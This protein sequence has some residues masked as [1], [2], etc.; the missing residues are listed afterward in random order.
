MKKWAKIDRAT[1]NVLK[2][3]REKELKRVLNK[4]YVWIE[5]VQGTSDV[6]DS[7]TH[8]LKESVVLPD[9]SDLSVDVDP[10][11]QR[12][13]NRVAVALTQDELDQRK[14]RDIAGLDKRMPRISEDIVSVLVC[15]GKLDWVD[16][17][18]KAQEVINNRR[19]KRGLQELSAS[20]AITF[21][22][23]YA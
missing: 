1:G 17:K 21:Q 16:L 3:K 5:E 23:P 4:K 13:I 22:D 15:R 10:S 7:A 19:T 8:K 11:V 20:S 18:P 14:I 9:L 6:Y 12:V 2:Y